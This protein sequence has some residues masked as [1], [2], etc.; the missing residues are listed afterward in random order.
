MD[1]MCMCIYI[2]IYLLYNTITFICSGRIRK[3]F[4]SCVDWAR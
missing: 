3:S 4:G 1:R 2:Y